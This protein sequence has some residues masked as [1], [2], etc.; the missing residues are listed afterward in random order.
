MTGGRGP[1]LLAWGN[2]GELQG[3]SW[4]SSGA[5]VRRFRVDPFAL[6]CV[7]KALE[8]PG[9]ASRGGARQRSL[10]GEPIKRSLATERTE[11]T[12]RIETKKVRGGLLPGRPRPA[13]W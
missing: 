3:A 9:A 11:P 6:R 2:T 12:E 10:L 7:S 4:Q 5:T 13:S 8:A 1:R